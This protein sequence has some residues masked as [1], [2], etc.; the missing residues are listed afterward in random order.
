VATTRDERRRRS[1]RRIL[2]AARTLFAERGYE[3]TTIRAVAAEAGVDPSLVIQHFGSKQDLFG[4]AVQAPVAVPHAGAGPEELVEQILETLGLKLGPLPPQ[5]LAMMRSMLTHPEAA[6]SVRNLLTRQIDQI[7]QGLPADDAA[8][9]AAL[10]M[11]VML[12]VTIGHQLL[13][14]SPMGEASTEDI[15]RLLRPALRALLEAD[16]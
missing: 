7:G 6:E 9:R 3:R 14:L 12:G 16:S 15:A 5:T 11:S 13:E 10:A 1:E 2:A 8:L 4:R